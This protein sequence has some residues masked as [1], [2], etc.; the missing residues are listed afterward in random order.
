MYLNTV[1][2]H[3]RLFLA[4]ET[5]TSPC[6]FRSPWTACPDSDGRIQLGAVPAKEGAV[7]L[8]W[9]APSKFV[10]I[11]SPGTLTVSLSLKNVPWICE[12][13]VSA[14]RLLF[15]SSYWRYYTLELSFFPFPSTRLAITFSP[16]MGARTAQ[17]QKAITAVLLRLLSTRRFWTLVTKCLYRADRPIS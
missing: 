16:S 15:R 9:E 11:R 1:P 3:L 2:L 8:K 12:K 17:N 5:M 14:P 7:T 6:A 10:F 4:S 13:D